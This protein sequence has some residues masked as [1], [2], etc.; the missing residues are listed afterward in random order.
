MESWYQQG[1]LGLKPDVLTFTNVI[2]CIA[3]SGRDDALE[4][5]LAFLNRMEDLHSSGFGDI[6]PN[7]FTYNCVI[8][9]A[10]KSKKA[11]KATLAL[12]ILRRMESVAVRPATVSYNNVINACAFSSRDDNPAEVLRIAFDTLRE[13]QE[14]PG[15]NWI[16][17]QTM[18][19]VVCSF[20]Q[21][22]SVRWQR[23][24]DIFRQCCDD[25]QL[26][27]AV[28]IQVKFAV[29]SAGFACLRDEATD[30]RTGLLHDNYTV[31]ARRLK[32]APTTK[33]IAFK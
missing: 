11:G 9:A 12:K 20:E 1:N 10:A 17:Y 28:L 22:E 30:E 6:R 18:L 31:H 13:A 33:Q 21:D 19:R 25:G 7:L 32:M 27:R 23:T 24:R 4:K 26:T 14:G 3:L 2:H 29:T 5:A 15:A 8:N 16:T